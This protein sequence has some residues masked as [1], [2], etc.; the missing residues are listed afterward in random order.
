MYSPYFHYKSV[1]FSRTQ[2]KNFGAQTILDLSHFQCMKKKKKE[3]KR[4][5]SK[6]V[7]KS[8]TGLEH[9]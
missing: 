3:K 1:T 7:M 9:E 8:N 5:C 2:N 6:E 4:H